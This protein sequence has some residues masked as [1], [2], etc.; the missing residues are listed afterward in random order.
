MLTRIRKRW[1]LTVSLVLFVFIVMI[2]TML[3][4]FLII[5]VLRLTGAIPFLQEPLPQQEGVPIF[6]RVIISMMLLSIL[7]GVPTAAFFSRVALRPIRQVI[8]ATHQVAEG[9]FKVRVDLHGIHELE[10]LSQS[11]NKMAA[12]LGSLETLR[13]DFVNNLSHELKTPLVSVR[14]FAKLLKSEDLTPQEK[15]E[16]LDI[17][18]LETERLAQLSTNILNLSRYENMEIITDKT[19]F[20]LDE[21]IRRT[22]VMT[23]PQWEAKDLTM[24]VDLEKLDFEGNEDLTQQIWLN[25]LDNAIKFSEPG[26]TVELRLSA[27]EEDLRFT[28]RDFGPGMDQTT[29]N[30]AFDRF[31][32]GDTSHASAGM[33]LGLT[34]VKRIVDIHGGHIGIT[35]EPGQGCT[36]NLF[37]P[38]F[39]TQTHTQEYNKATPIDI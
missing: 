22:V 21:Q 28:I 6:F 26:G 8:T 32:Q 23:E 17:I 27:C 24:L 9:D 4:S 1:G 29:K 10:E 2:T 11:F 39:P 14:G 15:Q 20:R 16:Y 31:F 30:R 18:I 37:L 19:L 25:L 12:D 33:G 13:D 35:S 38:I 5:W 3:L 36:I 7:L 34:M